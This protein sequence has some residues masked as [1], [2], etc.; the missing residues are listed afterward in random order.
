MK[1]RNWGVLL[2]AHGTVE[3]LADLPDFLTRIRRGRPAPAELIDEMRRRYELIG[4]SRLLEISRRQAALLSGELGMPV[5][6]AMRLSPPWVPDVAVEL[7]RAGAERLV[8]LPLAPFSVPVYADAAEAELPG[9]R[10]LRVPPWGT[11]PGVVG[12]QVA[13]IEPH[14]ERRADEHVL[15][16]AHSLPRHVIEQGDP[17]AQLFEQSARAIGTALACPYS[18]CY[19]SQGALSGEWLGPGLAEELERLARAGTRR[20]VVAPVGF[21]AEHIETLYDLDIEAK[22]QAHALGLEFERVPALG[23]D[24]AFITALAELVRSTLA[25]AE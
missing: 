11:Q 19:Q 15:L 12:A 10:T 9:T 22:A 24:A 17:Y 4:G 23:E 1:H 21:F 6:I 3:E 16:T 8:L 2:L 7:A 5:A 18:A 25:E 20:V 13:R 14:L